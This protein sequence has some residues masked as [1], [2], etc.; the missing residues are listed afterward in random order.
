[1]AGID[2]IHQNGTDYEIV[3]EIAP[4]FKT[5]QN[6]TA[7]QHVI[8]N[9]ALYTFKEDKSAGVWDATKVNGPFEVAKQISDLKEDLS[10]ITLGD[11]FL[12]SLGATWSQGGMNRDGEY[13]S[14]SRIRTDYIDIEALGQLTLIPPTGYAVLY[15]AY[16]SDKQYTKDSVWIT[17]PVTISFAD[18]KYIRVCFR[19]D[20]EVNLSPTEGTNLTATATYK[21]A[22]QVK[23]E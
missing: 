13:S 22:K 16:D 6:Y 1:M 19:K 17:S 7:G 11:A 10:G 3:P 4:L 12:Y 8:Y 14:W 20:P 9:A 5:T 21:V 18:E 23:G 15:V 2:F